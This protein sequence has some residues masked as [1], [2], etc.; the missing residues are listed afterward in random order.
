MESAQI[1][2]CENYRHHVTHDDAAIAMVKDGGLPDRLSAFGQFDSETRVRITGEV[3][4][5]SPLP[6]AL[7]SK[8]WRK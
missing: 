3:L 8:G 5:Q 1:P 6:L 7:V 2:R 4:S